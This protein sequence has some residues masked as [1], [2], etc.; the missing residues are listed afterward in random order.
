MKHRN[1]MRFIWIVALLAWASVLVRVALIADDCQWDFEVYYYAAKAHSAG[2]NPYDAHQVC[3]VAGKWKPE[4]LFFPYFPVSIFFFKPFTLLSLGQAKYLFFLMKCGLLMF[5]FFLWQ[6]KFLK[7]PAD[8]FFALFS[9]FA[10]NATIFLDIRS[11]NISTLEQALIWCAFFAF[12][13]KRVWCFSVLI[14]LASLLKITP[15]LFASLLFLDW[16][17]FKRSPIL[18]V[19]FAFIMIVCVTWLAEPVLFWQFFA[20]ASSWTESDRFSLSILNPSVF[21]LVTFLSQELSKVTGILAQ[22]ALQW[23]IYLAIVLP[24][25]VVSCKTFLKLDAGDLEQRKTA[26]CFACLVYAL[27]LPR[28]HDYQFI[29]LLVPTY[30]IMLQVGLVRAYPFI[31]V[32]SVISAEHQ[33]LPG[34]GFLFRVFWD[35]YPL[36]VAVTIWA[37]YVAKIQNDRASQADSAEIT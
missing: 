21:S 31:F 25:L 32:F 7:S 36:I 10:F 13:T 14:L 33:T 26:V 29:L 17:S 28:F 1:I 3:Q 2:L 37:F 34:S 35:Y 5:L 16:G 9:L 30:F 8:P 19:V 27:V 24:L 12:V 22:R 4:I 20:R 23:C 18:I 15:L 6:V 11:G